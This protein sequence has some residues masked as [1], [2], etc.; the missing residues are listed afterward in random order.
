MNLTI[1]SIK[2]VKVP[3]CLCDVMDVIY[4]S[5]LVLYIEENDENLKKNWT[6]LMCA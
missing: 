6:K 4:Y 2:S 1:W 5:I 3:C